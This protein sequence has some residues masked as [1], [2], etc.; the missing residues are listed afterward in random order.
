MATEH[1]GR[2]RGRDGGGG[3]GTGQVPLPHIPPSRAVL[4]SPVQ[5][6]ESKGD[7]ECGGRET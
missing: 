2:G 4:D 6:R 3:G 5:I 1:P 7:I